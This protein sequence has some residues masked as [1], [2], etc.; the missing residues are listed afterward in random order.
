MGD[1]CAKTLHSFF[2]VVAYSRSDGEKVYD[3]KQTITAKLNSKSVIPAEAGIK[4]ARYSSMT[5]QCLRRSLS[6]HLFILRSKV[7]GVEKAIL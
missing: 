3:G 7:T 5:M 6:K 4:Q 1:A 2:I